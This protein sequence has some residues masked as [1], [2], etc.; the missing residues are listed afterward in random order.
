MAL[1]VAV[2]VARALDAQRLALS[3]RKEQGTQTHSDAP[4]VSGAE[5]KKGK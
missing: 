3:E 5:R 2:V 4:G 1:V